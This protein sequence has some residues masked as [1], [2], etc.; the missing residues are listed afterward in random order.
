MQEDRKYKNTKEQLKVKLENLKEIIMFLDSDME[1]YEKIIELCRIY[2]TPEKFRSSYQ[3]IY[4]KGQDD[5]SFKDYIGRF[6]DIYNFY[7]ACQGNELLDNAKYI[8]SIESY[9]DD[10]EKA[11]AI[12]IDYIKSKDSYKFSGFLLRHGINDKIFE[13]YTKIIATINVKLYD[14]FLE[15]FEEN[16]K[17]RFISNRET[18]KE[19]SKEINENK[20]EVI[21]FLRRIP[22]I[23]SRDFVNKLMEFM[24]RNN[25]VEEY[26]TI[27]SYMVKNRL[28]DK[29]LT[30]PLNIEHIY[31]ERTIIG[32]REI[33]KEDNDVIINLMRESGYPMIRKSYVIVRNKY[34]NKDLKE[35]DKSKVKIFK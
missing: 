23:T 35:T 8:L 17:L 14:K 5:P 7:L 16:K 1:N 11:E 15:R 24:K 6:I 22:F 2:S 30:K 26:K 13:R 20:L 3:L 18:I 29:N 28:F 10:Y 21:E 9:L 25:T 19:L 4:N 34:L 32:G 12:I 33:T 27:M 31:K